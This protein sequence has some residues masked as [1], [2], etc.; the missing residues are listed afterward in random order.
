M[1]WPLSSLALLSLLAEG[2]AV[3]SFCARGS[4]THTVIQL[5]YTEKG[6]GQERHSIPDHASYLF[7]RVTS[8]ITAISAQLCQ[9]L[10]ISQPH[11]PLDTRCAE[12]TASSSHQQPMVKCAPHRDTL[13]AKHTWILLDRPPWHCTEIA[14]Q[15]RSKS[16]LDS[17]LSMA[18]EGARLHRVE[19]TWVSFLLPSESSHISSFQNYPKWLR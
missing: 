13:F 9:L 10:S 14:R 5:T 11:L 1:L 16:S 17:T 12:D 15:V 18:E 7:L 3:L 2:R 19:P 6:V 8:G 4:N